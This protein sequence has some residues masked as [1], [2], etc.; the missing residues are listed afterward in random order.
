[1]IKYLK[2]DLF[3]AKEELLIHGCNCFQCMGAGVAAI[4][5]KLYPEAQIVDDMSM[6]G[7]KKKLGSYT[8]TDPNPHYY[9]PEQDLIVVNAYTQFSMGRSKINADYEAIKKVMEKIKVDFEGYTKA[10][11]KIGAGLAGGDWEKIEKI[12][13][14]VFGDE[15]VVVYY[16]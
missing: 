3:K 7:D 2:G 16:I 1:M 8:C 6:Y 14:E 15:E 11:P 5:K 12:I 4:V 13:N 10:M 9:Y